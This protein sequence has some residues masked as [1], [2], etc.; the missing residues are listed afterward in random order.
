MPD[1]T[2]TVTEPVNEARALLAK[3]APGPW[4]TFPPGDIA[5]W[6]IYGADGWLTASATVID[7][8][9]DTPYGRVVGLP[10]YPGY[11]AEEGVE[12]AYQNAAL[13]A[14][15][16]R[17]LAALCEENELLRPVAEAAREIDREGYVDAM[18]NVPSWQRLAA[19]LDKLDGDDHA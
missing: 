15:A 19:A 18:A 5:G 16:P 14:A 4:C 12:R 7:S 13:I 1:P 2:P 6:G 9:V 8:D 10:S 11:T 17:L 3:A